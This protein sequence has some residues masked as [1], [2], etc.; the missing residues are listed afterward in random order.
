MKTIFLLLATILVG[1]ASF[2]DLE[3][4]S[5]DLSVFDTSHSSVGKKDSP[6]S[7]IRCRYVC[8]KKLY[9]E[10]KIAEAISFYKNSKEYN[11]SW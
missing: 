9:K 2:D 11:S 5:F 6:S 10:Q 3:P 8:D 7:H 1:E 4:R